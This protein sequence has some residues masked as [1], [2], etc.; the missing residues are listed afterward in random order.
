VA[1]KTGEH[2]LKQNKPDAV[3]ILP[4][5]AAPY[6]IDRI[7]NKLDCLI[8]AGGL[9]TQKKEVEYL[10]DNNVLAISTS[11]HELWDL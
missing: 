1:L 6:F 3:E 7:K 2:L 9:I 4:G 5:I 10:L 8:I 11:V